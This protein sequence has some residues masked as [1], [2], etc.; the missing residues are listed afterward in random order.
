M[1]VDRSVVGWAVEKGE[2]KVAEMGAKWVA[3]ME[4]LMA[5]EMEETTAV[6]KVGYLVVK[7]AE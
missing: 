4:A 6:E 7:M 5:D 1:K 2:M 3:E